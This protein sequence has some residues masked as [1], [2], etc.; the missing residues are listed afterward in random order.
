MNTETIYYTNTGGNTWIMDVSQRTIPVLELFLTN[1]NNNE[2][3]RD[4]PNPVISTPNYNIN[5]QCVLRIEVV[6]R[7]VIKAGSESQSTPGELPPRF[8][9][10]LPTNQSHGNDFMRNSNFTR[11]A[12]SRR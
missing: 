7:A 10:N 4:N 2:L 6:E 5:F 11:L 8:T 3:I 12:N 9:S 1:K